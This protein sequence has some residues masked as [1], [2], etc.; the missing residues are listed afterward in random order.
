MRETRTCPRTPLEWSREHPPG[1][2]RMVVPSALPLKLICDVTRLWRN[3]APLGNFLRT[4]LCSSFVKCWRKG[5]F[6]WYHPNISLCIDGTKKFTREKTTQSLFPSS[7][8]WGSECRTANKYS[9]R[10]AAFP[11]GKS[12]KVLPQVRVFK[13]TRFG[14]RQLSNNALLGNGSDW[15]YS[16]TARHEAHI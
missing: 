13:T 6:C 4:P 5:I 2:P 16:F 8:L 12:V 15:K 7:Q 1:L 10:F 11:V 9:L 14:C 3:F